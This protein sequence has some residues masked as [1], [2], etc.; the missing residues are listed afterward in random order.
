MFLFINMDSNYSL[1]GKQGRS[2]FYHL[3]EK[4]L[5]AEVEKQKTTNKNSLI[6]R[7]VCVATINQDLSSCSDE[8]CAVTEHYKQF[9]LKFQQNTL[10]EGV[11]GLLLLYHKCIIHLLE[12]SSEVLTLIIKDLSDME[13]GSNCLLKDCRIL[14]FSHCLMGRL[15]SSWSY[16]MLNQSLSLNVT[17]VHTPSEELLVQDSLAKIYKYCTWLLKCKGIS[18][19]QGTQKQDF[20]VEEQAVIH[21]CQSQVLHSP[22]T[23]LQ[24]YMKPVHIL[25]DAETVW[26][27]QHRLLWQTN[28]E[29]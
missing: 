27:T 9:L 16:R 24:S 1:S 19:G 23:F 15:F 8:R 14:V 10:T 3:Y 12:S 22:T 26:P 18:E 28:E 11:S 29:E 4:S 17:A 5:F 13:K 21:L 20:L 25:T 7:L 6:H 2:S